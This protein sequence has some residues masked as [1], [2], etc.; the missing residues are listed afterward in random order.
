MPFWVETARTSPVVSPLEIVT[1]APTIWVS[2]ASL[3]AIVLSIAAALP[4]SVYASVAP[5][6]TTG[7]LLTV[8]TLIVLVP[9]L[10]E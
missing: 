5:A 6:V 1:V 7:R 4:F 9:E 8:N 2:S 10:V 3:R